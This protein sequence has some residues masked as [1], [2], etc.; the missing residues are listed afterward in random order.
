MKNNFK[1]LLKKI[2]IIISIVI[3]G[4]D[5][6]S[7][8]LLESYIYDYNRAKKYSFI[9][10]PS[11]VTPAF[12]RTFM[13]IWSHSVEKGLSSQPFRPGFGQA[14]IIELSRLIMMDKSEQNIKGNLGSEKLS[15][16]S[17]VLNYDKIHFGYPLDE[18]TL[19]SINSIKS[20]FNP[21]VVLPSSV[22]SPSLS[23]EE[24][25][26]MRDVL[27]KRRSIRQFNQYQTVDNDLID[28]A[29]DIAVCAPTACNRQPFK[30]RLTSDKERI[31][32]ILELQG[33]SGGFSCIPSLLIV[34]F[35]KNYYHN[36]IER[37]SGYIDSG[38]FVM[39]LIYALIAFGVDSCILNNAFDS[40]KDKIMRLVIPEINVNEDFV[41]FIAI[42]Y[43]IPNSISPASHKKQIELQNL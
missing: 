32:K 4:N 16:I 7:L 20:T 41:V 27:V 9:G 25:V 30:V 19:A 42:G 6:S 31:S 29:L 35:E 40:K 3:E 43:K 18:V 36:A 38:I 15:A 10:K 21:E 26:I 1:I 12:S 33:G 11:K 24:R 37:N 28:K 23:D 39:N 34:T 14:K 8:N 2:K 17:N 5:E 22:V 13:N